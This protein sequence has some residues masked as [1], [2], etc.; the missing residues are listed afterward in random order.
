MLLIAIH[1]DDPLV[2][3][4]FRPAQNVLHGASIAAI[5][6]VANHLHLVLG[7]KLRSDIAAA[8][9]NHQNIARKYSNIPQ[10]ALNRFGLVVNR[11][12]KQ[13]VGSIGRHGRPMQLG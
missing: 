3:I 4:K 2:S 12:R 8:I 10:H 11:N 13:N 9:V 7:Q 1:G 6:R 5:F